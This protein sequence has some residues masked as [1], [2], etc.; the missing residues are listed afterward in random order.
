M[1]EVRV[2]VVGI[3]GSMNLGVIA[4]TCVNFGV[5]ELYLV[6]PIASIEEALKYAARGR[7]LLLK[8]PIV[9]DI[10]EALKGVDVSVA[11]SAIGFSEGDLVRQAIPID[12]LVKSIPSRVTKLALIFG[13]ESTGLTREEILRSDFLSTIPANPEYPVLNISQSVAIFLWEL[14]KQKSVKPV[15]V[16][17]RAGRAEV[18]NILLL[19]REITASSI[20]NRD[21][22]ARCELVLR[23]TLYRSAPSMYETRVLLYWA[24]RVLRKLKEQHSSR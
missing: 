15:N 2:V 22:Q 19:L 21:K 20:S 16:P 13:R 7:D 23:R 9:S 8:S 24:R 3:E 4:R 5:E 1:V 11:T 18:E 10:E 12:V 17:P 14:W 6:N